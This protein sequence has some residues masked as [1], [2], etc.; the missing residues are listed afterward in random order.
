MFNA[1]W[2]VVE[3]DMLSG[4]VNASPRLSTLSHPIVELENVSSREASMSWDSDNTVASTSFTLIHG[5]DNPNQKSSAELKKEIAAIEAEI[6]R[7]EHHLLSLYQTTFLDRIT[8]NNAAR[9]HLPNN[10]GLRFQ[11][12]PNQRHHNLKP[13][14]Q[15][16]D[17]IYADQ[18]LPEAWVNSENQGDTSFHSTSTKDN[19]R[20]D[21]GRHSLADHLGAS[22]IVDSLTT[23]DRL[24]EDIVRCISSIYFRLAC[25]THSQKGSS[26][27]P[28]SPLSSSSIFSSHNP[29]D[30][31]SPHS[32]DDTPRFHQLQGLEHESGSYAGMVEIGKMCFDNDTFNY[33]T[34]KLK[35][36]RSMVSSL[37]KV[38]PR[39]MRREEKLVFWIN[40][41]NAL[42]MH[43]YLAYGTRN[44]AKGASILKAAYNVGGHCINACIIQNSIFG[45]QSHFSEPWLQTLFSPG[46][47]CKNGSSRHVYALEY[48]E[49]LL[50]FALCSGAYSDPVVR[51]YT[52]K[53]IF[54]ELRIAKDEFI[55]ARVHIQKEAKIF[56]PKML[57]YFER[58]VG[59]G[60]SGLLEMIMA[61]LKE[62]QQKAL[63]KCMA[64]GKLDKSI[65]WLPQSSSFRYVIHG[66]LAKERS[67]LS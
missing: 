64:K 53:K 54:E 22:C 13:P 45:I 14:V 58:D 34:V 46:K 23:P 2:R 5:E 29:C 32:N 55:Q 25:P 16:R 27:S 48:P 7:L 38:D 51:V 36:F 31:W 28:S 12:M 63:R 59:V 66:D 30:S 37:E 15:R 17:I 24:S 21:S 20:I 50:H 67:K 60:M 62:G 26:V 3:I 4:L 10:Q 40:I 19:N 49:P 44:R 52:A 39:K 1:N 35:N 33:A 57:S 9:I 41:H 43:A 6:L 61:S 56:L 11:N 18:T 47:K 65:H 8:I 42:I